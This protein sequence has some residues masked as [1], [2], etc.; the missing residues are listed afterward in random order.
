MDFAR[1]VELFNRGDDQA[2]CD[3]FYAD[4]AVM[5]TSDRLVEGKPAL[6]E[7]LA[8]A[9]DGV[10]ELLR[11]QHVVQADDCILAEIDIDFFAQRDRDDF[12]FQPL[13]R[14][15]TITAKFFVVYELRDGKVARLKTS[16]WPVGRATSVPPDYSQLLG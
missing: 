10:R 5:Q 4:D 2:L 14:G 8:W 16:R 11:P 7:F 6:L 13:K 15:E 9:H 12:P 3:H 1:Y